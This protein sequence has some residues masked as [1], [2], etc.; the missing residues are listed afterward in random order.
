MT[1]A[2]ERYTH[3]S[4]PAQFR[5]TDDWPSVDISALHIEARRRFYRLRSA[6]ATYVA[7]G[8][9]T[10]AASKGQCSGKLVLKQLNRCLTTTADGSIFGWR[11]LIP[12]TRT[13]TYTRTA[14]ARAQSSGQG[15][16]GLFTQLLDQ[17]PDIDRGLRA[18]ILKRGK[19]MH[20]TK[21]SLKSLSRELFRLCEAA[22]I[23][24][25]CYPFTAKYR[26]IRTL[27]QYVDEVVNEVPVHGIEARY[28]RRATDCLRVQTGFTKFW[29]ALRPYDVLA[30]D[31]HKVDC[32]GTVLLNGPRGLIRRPIQRLWIVAVV[33][34]CSEA[35][36]G[37]HVSFRQ[38]VNARAI[39]SAISAALTK[40]TPRALTIDGLQYPASSGLPTGCIPQLGTAVGAVITF[41]NA[42][43]HLA[44]QIA[45]KVR[46]RLG[47]S[48]CFN[49]VGHWEHNSIV[50]RTFGRLESYGFHRLPNTTGS[51]PTDPRRT[52]PV[53]VA[54]DYGIEL[55]E[56]LDLLDVVIATLNAIPNSSDS[57]SP[58]ECLEQAL[59]NKRSPLLPRPL[60]PLFGDAPDIGTLVSMR[61]VRG[62]VATGRRPYIEY[63]QSR[64]SSP[65]L[66]NSFQLIDQ[67]LRL[68]I[69]PSNLNRIKAFRESGAYFDELIISGI[70]S[71]TDPSLETK[72]DVLQLAAQKKLDI[73][74]YP[75]PVDAARQYFYRK[76]ADDAEKKPQ[77]ISSAATQAARLQRA[78][79]DQI[80]DAAD[81]A[82]LSPQETF[83]LPRGLASQKLL[84][85]PTWKIR[86]KQPI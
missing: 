8:K 23:P 49:P 57:L 9:L 39:E 79:Q 48:F 7:T 85:Q 77:R 59:A 69:D 19:Q 86:E 31:A 17:N 67:R 60:P 51:S 81:T 27:A 15:A 70:W 13:T 12:H 62:N 32:I 65:K 80:P 36:L 83:S 73:Q 6:I 58:M 38:E 76:A 2:D 20:E 4:V 52:D 68:H 54:L 29:P 1:R 14:P 41:D 21:I 34:V 22:G 11:A 74:D 35:V 16:A 18:L 45:D 71:R 63:L 84:R 56:L 44:D 5:H 66:A 75:D 3:A 37:Y 61:T 64:Y 46:R 55:E 53:R 47:C 30:I 24:G 25:H 42:L 72:E 10:D 40:W 33:D 50:E 78:Q 43:V 26:A 28:G 82:N